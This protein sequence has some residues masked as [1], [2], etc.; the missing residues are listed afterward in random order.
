MFGYESSLRGLKFNIENF[1]NTEIIGLKLLFV[2]DWICKLCIEYI[3]KAE[4]KFLIV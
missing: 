1:Q 2:I 3:L 4:E